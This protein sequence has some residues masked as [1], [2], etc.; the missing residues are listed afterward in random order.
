MANSKLQNLT[1]ITTVADT[2]IVYVVA[3]EGGLLVDRKSTK[4]N[5]VK[6][7]ADKTNVLELD[8]AAAF[9]PTADYH[10]ATKKYVDDN[11]GGGPIVASGA[12]VLQVQIFS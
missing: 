7:K 1:E 6:E 9:T 2:D 12:D 11:G 3:D 5:L 10:P 8:N 4:A